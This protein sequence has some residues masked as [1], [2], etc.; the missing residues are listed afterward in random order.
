MRNFEN[1]KLV[2]GPK[3]ID[4]FKLVTGMESAI[5]EFPLNQQCTLCSGM[6]V[7]DWEHAVIDLQDIY[8]CP[9]YEEMSALKQAL[10]RE[11]EIALQVHPKQSEYVNA[12]PYRLHLWRNKNITLT[13]EKRLIRRV[14]DMY[15]EA[16]KYFSGERKEVFLEDSRVLIIFCGDNW[17]PW[18]EVCK[19]K[20][21]YWEPEQAA[22]QFNIS[23][24]FDLNK[25]HIMILWD[26][27][28]FILPPKEIV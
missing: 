6:K 4:F 15:E 21:R 18:E 1:V 7:G 24:E 20:K 17:L 12:C 23:K 16:K 3:I 2:R 26:A 10:F 11:D 27:E 19:I 9:T 28:D 5:F 8:R 25:E 14:A 22:V 13:A